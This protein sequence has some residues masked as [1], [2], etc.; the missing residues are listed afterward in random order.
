MLPGAGLLSKLM[1]PNCTG[2]LRRWPDDVMA[3]HYVYAHDNEWATGGC[4]AMR[5]TQHSPPDAEATLRPQSLR[6]LFVIVA[7]AANATRALAISNLGALSE[8]RELAAEWVVVSHDDRCALWQADV[9]AAAELLRVPFSCVEWPRAAPLAPGLDPYRPKLPLQLHA[10]DP[11]LKPSGL[12]QQ[13]RIDAFDAVWLPDADIALTQEGLSNFFVRWAC[14]FRAGPP[15]VAQPAL[16]GDKGRTERSQNFWVFNYARE[17]QPEGRVSAVGALA[18][19]TYYV[20]QQAPIF[21]PGFLQWFVGGVGRRLAAMQLA[22][23]ADLATDQLWCRA[24]GR[25]AQL[26]V[27]NHQKRAAIIAKAAQRRPMHRGGR[28]ATNAL[29]QPASAAAAST[30]RRTSCAVI[31][32]PFRH[33]NRATIR[34]TPAFWKGGQSVRVQAEQ[35]WPEYWM[36]GKLL[37]MYKVASAHIDENA[38]LWQDRCML[39]RYASLKLGPGC[40]RQ[41]GR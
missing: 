9:G 29:L 1:L 10:L 37:A 34:Q 19:H 33:R 23:G 2:S 13:P 21:D 16:H 6:V 39:R 36:D 41:R 5:L 18:V 4:C 15:L 22:A 8:L 28:P 17:W 26:A 27:V 20:E 14:A 32:V 38:G 3:R 11:Y 35:A 24:A 31:P 12:R 7:D 30:L 25:Y 40:E